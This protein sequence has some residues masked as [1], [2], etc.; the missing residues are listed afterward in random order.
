M[1]S[2]QQREEAKTAQSMLA[3][4]LKRRL[5]QN[6][7][8]LPPWNWRIDDVF[9][10]FNEGGSKAPL[11]W[12]F[13]SWVEPIAL[14]RVLGPE[15]PLVAMHSLDKV[16]TGLREKQTYFL[17]IID[18]YREGILERTGTDDFVLGGNC[19]GAGIMETV[20]QDILA[21]TGVARPLILLEHTPRFAYPGETRILFGEQSQLFNPFLRG[22]NPVPRWNAQFTSYEVQEIPGAHGKYF[23]S[24]GIDALAR[25][26]TDMV[27]RTQGVPSLVANS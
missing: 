8:N 21:R 9:V 2:R 10:L 13:N 14:A 17:S 12:C 27:Q 23:R 26:V 7:G 4:E 18:L 6:I 24:P 1:N 19:Q 5:E 3:A 16:M 22:E 11:F 20:A 15:Q 25:T